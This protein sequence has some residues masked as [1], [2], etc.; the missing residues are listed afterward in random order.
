MNRRIC[1]VATLV[2]I[3]AAMPVLWGCGGD[4]KADKNAKKQV[5]TT[6]IAGTV[7]LFS[8]YG[9][10]LDR[11]GLAEKIRAG[12]VAKLY[13]FTGKG[14]ELKAVQDVVVKPVDADGNFLIENVPVGRVNLAVFVESADGVRLLTAIVPYVPAPGV[15]NL[16]VTPESDLEFDVFVQTL[17]KLG[18]D[19]KNKVAAEQIDSVFIKRVVSAELFF[20]KSGASS[21]VDNLS[22]AI[23]PAVMAGLMGFSE[24]ISGSG[25]PVADA[26]AQKVWAD[27]READMR[28]ALERE[29][30]MLTNSDS[31]AGDSYAFLKDELEDA[32]A[33]VPSP[34]SD[35]P[36]FGTLRLA[37]MRSASKAVSCLSEKPDKKCAANPQR[38]QGEYA[39]TLG[40]LFD[41]ENQ[42]EDIRARVAIFAGSESSDS[43]NRLD[44]AAGAA[45]GSATGAASTLSMP[46]SNS[47]LNDIENLLALTAENTAPVR[48]LLD[49]AKSQSAYTRQTAV[50]SARARLSRSWEALRT[51]RNFA[52]VGFI[53]MKYSDVEPLESQLNDRAYL[54]S[55]AIADPWA[56]MRDVASE[57]RKFFGE[58][59]T[60]LEP[61][62]SRI[63]GKYTKLPEADR[64]RIYYSAKM[65]MLASSV[66]GVPAALFHGADDDGDGFANDVEA[67]LGSD[68]EKSDSRPAPVTDK[69]PES[70]LP[71]LVAD[72]DKDGFPDAVEVMAGTGANDPASRPDMMKLTF[73]A[74][75]KAPC[76][77]ADD[78][79]EGAPAVVTLTGKAAFKDAAAQGVVIGLYRRPVFRGEAPAFVSAA[80]SDAVGLFVI[81]AEKGDYFISAFVDMNGDGKPGEKEAAGYYGS[82]YPKKIGLEGDYAL[83][84][85][86]VL[87]GTVGGSV[88]GAGEALDPITKE[89][90]KSCPAG[91]SPDA[92]TGSCRC[93]RGKILSITTLTCEASC[94]SGT[95]AEPS[96]LRCGCP[97]GA[98]FDREAKTCVCGSGKT[99]DAAT[100]SCSCAT[101]FLNPEGTSCSESCP[102]TWKGNEA[103]HVC[104][105]AEGTKKD[106]I[107]GMCVCDNGG[108][109]DTQSG[110]C[111][112]DCPKGY[113]KDA[114]GKACVCPK[115]EVPSAIEG[116]CKCDTGFERDAKTGK[117][118]MPCPLGAERDD[119]GECKRVED[120]DKKAI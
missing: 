53:G 83:P 92:L 72:A 24:D 73:C 102:A 43:I 93:E 90:A 7:D 99:F 64:A 14:V 113:V 82:S 46:P 55:A 80:V 97:G 85:D 111:A 39:E 54:L 70:L 37:R 21:S 18:G 32:A 95:V 65:M 109:Y 104:E 17:K 11:A 31:T 34:F 45:G 60:I 75:K 59:D 41:E 33:G 52:L 101:G 112:A 100:G 25:R 20:L 78:K 105:C 4:K 74:E 79:A 19:E 107:S 49:T 120:K 62:R 106:D 23:A 30:R 94:P 103:T 67:T 1:A 116:G 3:M 10:A 68:S 66:K 110:K 35:M 9:I 51:A 26:A 56:P 50:S 15:M 6:K 87:I 8:G 91:T 38:L 63:N 29:R 48:S 58:V 119:K 44:V 13:K 47:A 40:A 42:A 96:G 2:A 84:A 81:K 12:A 86:V 117:C 69:S 16:M 61:L 57:R 5:A 76:K 77:V 71:E 108:L 28:V 27:V 22:A 88:C 118:E 89:C 36:K 114:H 115:D 98:I